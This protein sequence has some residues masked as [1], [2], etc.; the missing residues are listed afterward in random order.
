VRWDPERQGALI[1]IDPKHTA[2]PP[3]QQKLSPAEIRRASP[4]ALAGFYDRK[5]VPLGSLTVLAPTTMVKIGPPSMPPTAIGQMEYAD[6]LRYLLAELRPDQWQQITSPAGLPVESLTPAQQAWFGRIAPGSATLQPGGET[7]KPRRASPKEIAGS[8]LRLSRDVQLGL[9]SKDGEPGGGY[10]YRGT[11]LHSG[12]DKAPLYWLSQDDE[13]D[14]PGTPSYRRIMPNAL[15][16]SDVDLAPMGTNAAVLRRPVSLVPTAP[17]GLTIG[18]LIQRAAK[19]TGWE[20]YADPRVARLP[21]WVRSAPGG[22]RS[23]PVT[24]CAVCA[25]P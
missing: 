9:N 8:R 24:S 18:G 13:S 21:V 19:V 4:R 25:L 22:K 10:S 7:G 23:A 14:P 17:E 15:K 16:P 1:A 11:S 6:A 3:S 12:T 20:L 5:L 2:L